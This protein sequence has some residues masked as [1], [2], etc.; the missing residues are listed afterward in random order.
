MTPK[1]AHDEW[2]RTVDKKADPVTEPANRC[3]L[4][5]KTWGGHY[6]SDCWSPDSAD[7]TVYEFAGEEEYAVLTAGLLRGLD[8][9]AINDGLWDLHQQ[10]LKETQ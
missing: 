9:R 4:C 6:N 8:S 3:P 7:P 5:L 1:E 2:Y 10:K